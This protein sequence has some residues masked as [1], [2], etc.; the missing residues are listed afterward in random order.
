MAGAFAGIGDVTFII[1]RST[2]LAWIQHPMRKWR[3]MRRP[4]ARCAV[5]RRINSELDRSRP[6]DAVNFYQRNVIEPHDNARYMCRCDV[7]RG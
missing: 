5:E 4:L 3:Q 2:E 1:C 6:H 7:G